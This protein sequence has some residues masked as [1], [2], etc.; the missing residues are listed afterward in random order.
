MPT[1][2][3]NDTAHVGVLEYDAGVFTPRTTEVIAATSY[4]LARCSGDGAVVEEVVGWVRVGVSAVSC[5]ARA[6]SGY[7]IRALLVFNIT[8]N[9]YL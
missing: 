7:S 1:R 5:D 3:V 4:R 9:S 6:M 8:G 2:T